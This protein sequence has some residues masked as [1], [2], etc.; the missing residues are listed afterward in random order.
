[1]IFAHIK[2]VNPSYSFKNQCESQSFRE[3]IEA[4]TYKQ[5]PTQIGK[6]LHTEFNRWRMVFIF[7][8]IN[9]A[10]YSFGVIH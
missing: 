3:R 6:D 5:W 9:V 2:A 4:A 8:P 10:I 1:M 7:R